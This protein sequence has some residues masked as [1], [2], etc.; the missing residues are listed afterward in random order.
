MKEY[1]SYWEAD[2]NYYNLYFK[3][4]KFGKY[5]YRIELL[6]HNN[7]VWIS[8]S[9]GT[10]R[11]QLDNFEPD[12]I[13]RNNGILPLI[14]IKDEIL[15]LSDTF[16]K[17]FTHICITWADSQRREV[18]KRLLNYGFTINRSEGILVLIKENKNY[19]L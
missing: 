13:K 3:Q 4:K 18:Y 10:K 16:T 8:V 17:D 9:S 1:L 5:Y 7:K 12:N 15:N 19:L 14:W 2:T 6:L 11:K